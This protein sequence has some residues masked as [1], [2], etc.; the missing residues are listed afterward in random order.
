M[1]LLDE[2]IPEWHFG[3]RHQIVVDAPA[4]RVAETLESM[5]PDRDASWFVRAL[6]RARGLSIPEG[7][8]TRD[9]LSA[10]GFSVLGERAGREIVFGIAGKFWAPREMA[11]LARVPNADAFRAFA[12]TG[13]AKG[14]MTFRI[15]PLYDG[16]TVLMTETRVWCSD[17]RARLLFGLY[18]TLIRI[19][20]GLIRADMLRSIAHRATS[21][22][23]EVAG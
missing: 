9:T 6:F 14:A 13:E 4:D 21:P 3:N 23:L 17:G 1:D 7:G 19:P 5:R 15:E 10:T 11:N 12:R 22:A 16:R 2:I 20:S 18:W 8:T